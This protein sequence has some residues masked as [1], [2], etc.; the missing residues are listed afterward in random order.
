MG[1]PGARSRKAKVNLPIRDQLEDRYRE[2]G[3]AFTT[4][5]G[6]KLFLFHYFHRDEPMP[7]SNPWKTGLGKLVAPN[8]FVNIDLLMLL[9][10][11]YDANK[12]CI[13]FPDGTNLV[14]FAKATI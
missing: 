1:S 4:V 11:H 2:I 6:H 10:K 7:I 14:H 8:V 9:V 13:M 12:R 3:D 5:R